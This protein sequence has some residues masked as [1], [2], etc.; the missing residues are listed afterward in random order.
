MATLF[1]SEYADAPYRGVSAAVGSVALEPAAVEQTVAIAGA[2]A[3][4]ASFGASTSL[5]RIHTDV[6]CCILFGANPTATTTKKRLAADQTEYFAVVP[7]Q[8][9]AVI[10]SA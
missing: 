4:S 2:S 10:A 8:K 3:Q 9:V 5:V 7:G 6:A 1:I